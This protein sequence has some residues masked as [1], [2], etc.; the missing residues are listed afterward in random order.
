MGGTSPIWLPRAG[1]IQFESA[2]YETPEYAG[3]VTVRLVRTGVG[4]GGLSNGST[5]KL[6]VGYRTEDGTAQA[7]V[8]YEPVNGTLTW[9]DGDAS[10]KE[11][12][13]PILND[14]MAEEDETVSLVLEEPAENSWLNSVES[15]EL[16][17]QAN[18]SGG[19][20]S[21]GCFVG[22]LSVDD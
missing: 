11:F 14:S 17:I 5:G 19:G 10:P 2:M 6:T 15:A 21:G 22:A 18:D 13:V 16:T 12:Q 1:S 20:S 8:D 3:S 7:G 9:A 4:K